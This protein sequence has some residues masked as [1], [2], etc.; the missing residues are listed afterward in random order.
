MLLPFER[1]AEK[2]E[3]T[4]RRNDAHFAGESSGDR[5]A[6][7][8]FVLSFRVRLSKGNVRGKWRRSS[9]YLSRIEKRSSEQIF[10]MHVAVRLLLLEYDH[11]IGLSQ[12]C[13]CGSQLAQFDQFN[14]NLDVDKRIHDD[15]L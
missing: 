15:R 3:E 5:L 6:T 13:A 4:G 11:R 1:L 7:L 9:T 2:R 12:Q 14:H 10:E 8:F